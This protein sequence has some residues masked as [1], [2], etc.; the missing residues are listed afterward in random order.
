MSDDRPNDPLEARLIELEIR[1]TQ[2]QEELA[3][4]SGVLHAQQQELDAL[5]R[6]LEFLRKRSAAS[7]PGQVDASVQEKPP[8][9]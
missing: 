8:H 6:D 2:Q 1:Y 5:R 7:E 3:T 4:M 9:Y